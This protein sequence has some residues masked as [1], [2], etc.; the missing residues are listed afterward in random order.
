MALE[1]GAQQ[2]TSCE[3]DAWKATSL[4]SG[5]LTARALETVVLKQVRMQTQDKMKT[6]ELI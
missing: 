4:E 6:L 3:T 2:G 5:S 1:T